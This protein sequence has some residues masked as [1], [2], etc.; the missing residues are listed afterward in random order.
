VEDDDEGFELAREGSS[1]EEGDFY[2]EDP[3]FGADDQK[4]KV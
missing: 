3:H 1:D 2:F 4:L